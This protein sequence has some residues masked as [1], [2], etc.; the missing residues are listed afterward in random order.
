MKDISSLNNN[1]PWLVF[2]L[3]KSFFALS[4]ENITSIT[5]LPKNIT[6]PVLTPSYIRG[7]L[8]LREEVIPLVDM[9]MLFDFPTAASELQELKKITASA[10]ETHQVWIN[11]L[12]RCVEENDTFTK[13]LDPEKCA[14][15]KWL[16]SFDSKNNVINSHLRKITMP[17]R[18]LH[19]EGR[20]IVELQ[21]QQPS[22]ERDKK[23]KEHL[24]NVTKIIAPTIF[25]ILTKIQ[26]DWDIA[27]KEMVIIFTHNNKKI[28]LIV[29]EVQSVEKLEI[30]NQEVDTDMQSIAHFFN[31]LARS[32]RTNDVI[33]LIDET[34][35]GI[36]FSE[37]DFDI[38]QNMQP[39]FD[40]VEA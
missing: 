15:G 4:C 40:G 1:L 9:R 25:A 29:D 27:R 31:S 2:N 7:L 20:K 8:N 33:F 5:I 17:H 35:L 16:L 21:K 6:D 22:T 24:E 14:F 19:D 34:E 3:N 36:L 32:T 10:V 37:T 38:A 26:E 12:T 23:I 13:E 18:E 30:L 39:K 28:G 11:E